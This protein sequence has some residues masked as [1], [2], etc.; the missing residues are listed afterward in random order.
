MDTNTFAYQNNYVR[1]SKQTELIGVN[2]KFVF[3]QKFF[4]EAR[5]FSMVTSQCTIKSCIL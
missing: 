2:V 1:F 4:C 5:N 3:P